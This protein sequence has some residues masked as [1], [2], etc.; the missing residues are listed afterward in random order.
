MRLVTGPIYPAQKGGEL[1][2]PRMDQNALQPTLK[3]SQTVGC[4]LEVELPRCA[5]VRMPE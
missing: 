5:R 2:R 4:R 1:K 3:S